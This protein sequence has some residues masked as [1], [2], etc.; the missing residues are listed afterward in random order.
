MRWSCPHCGVN[1][2]VA[3]DKL[4]TGWS[5]SR[6]YKCA[7]FAL[8]R[9]SDVNL[10]KVDRA[11]AGEQILLPEATEDPTALMSQNAT[12]HLARYMSNKTEAPLSRA[13]SMTEK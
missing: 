2:A 13:P 6:C 1:L 4:G 7:G 3:D 9:R 11:P 8:V 10:I 5:F 12:N